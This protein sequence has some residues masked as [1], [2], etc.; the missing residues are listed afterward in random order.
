MY[1]SPTKKASVTYMG[2]WPTETD[3][4][5]CLPQLLRLPSQVRAL[6]SRWS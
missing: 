4:H 2:A 1:I 5:A 6:G 3:A